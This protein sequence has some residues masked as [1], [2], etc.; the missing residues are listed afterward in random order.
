V[1]VVAV[2]LAFSVG[3]YQGM[4]IRSTLADALVYHSA[5]TNHDYVISPAELNRVRDLSG[6]KGYHVQ[7]GTVDGFAAGAAVSS[8]LSASLDA[9]NPNSTSIN[10]N[11]VSGIT[12][13]PMLV[14]NVKSTN[15]NSILQNIKIAATGDALAVA[16][17][18]TVKLYDGS[19]QL[20]AVA[21]SGNVI[22]FKDLS[23]SVLK[24]ATKSLTIK[25]DFLGGVTNGTKIRLTITPTT[26]ITYQGTGSTTAYAT[27]SVI[28]GNYMSLYSDINVSLSFSSA[29]SAYTYNSTTPA[30]SYA[31]GVITFNAKPSGGTLTLPTSDNI[32]VQVC[33]SNASCTST[34]VSKSI[35]VSPNQNILDGNTATITVNASY[36]PPTHGYYY[37]KITKIDSN[38][39]GMLISQTS[40]LDNYRTPAVNAQ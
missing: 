33:N 37:F 19:T 2:L 35:T 7:S 26:G 21:P 9:G 13:V 11:S 22:S 6:S 4:T 32:I 3:V 20:G 38:V 25:A 24:D 23:I 31:T 10:V 17:L 27:G 8:K 34:G 12:N 39:G 14:F 15:G 30:K 40:G 1:E 28:N 36:T 18:K 16:K 5:D 29:T